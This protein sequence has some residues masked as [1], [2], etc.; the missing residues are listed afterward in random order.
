MGASERKT[1]YKLLA[2]RSPRVSQSTTGTVLE[3]ANCLHQKTAVE[4]LIVPKYYDKRVLEP[5]KRG[6]ELGILRG[7][8]RGD[9]GFP[10]IF[11][12]IRR[13]PMCHGQPSSLQTPTVPLKLTNEIDFGP[14][15]G[16][17]EEPRQRCGPM[18]ARLATVRRQFVGLG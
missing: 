4:K 13:R 3:L 7:T 17:F 15:W 2:T 1:N 10:L 8:P 9:L 12:R 5:P 6:F 16:P 18:G 11:R 14:I